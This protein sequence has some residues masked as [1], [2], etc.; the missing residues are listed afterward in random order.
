MN[1]AKK[2]FSALMCLILIVSS[3]SSCAPQETADENSTEPTTAPPVTNYDKAGFTLAYLRTDSLNPYNISGETN[4]DISRLMY[5][6]LFNIGNDFKP[7]P[8]IAESYTFTE[9]DVITVKIKPNL[10]FTDGSA[11]TADDVVYSF[12]LAKRSDFYSPSLKNIT[13][14]S[15]NGNGNIVFTLKSSNPYEVANLCFPVIKKNSDSNASGSSDI[16]SFPIGSGRYF[17]KE[18]NGTEKLIAN[19]TRLGSYIP[20]YNYISLRDVTEVSSVTGLFDLNEVDFYTQSFSEGNYKRYSGTSTYYDTTN[21]VFLGINADCKVLNESKVRR[22]LSL[23]IDRET[24]A[25]SSFSGFAVP[26]S[27]AYH[28]SFYGIKGCSYIPVKS[29]AESAIE[30]LKDAGFKNIS[31]TYSF[32]YNDDGDKLELRLLVNKENSFK[33]SMARNIQ[34]TLAEAD[35]VVNIKEYSYNN[36]IQAIKSGSYDLYIGEVK[37]PESFSLN[38]FFNS[39]G[40]ASF[41]IDNECKSA[42]AY[43]LLLQ[44]E[45]TM[46]EFLDTFADD[47]PF[48]PVLYRR[49]V[50]IKKTKIKT[51]PKTIVSDYLYNINEWTAE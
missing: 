31:S 4:R 37:L 7:I 25:A 44:G 12:V 30:L 15:S 27:T 21:L 26:T 18:E 36:Y 20:V 50:A 11:L 6:P 39:N 41:G 10:K 9:P 38:A 33:L 14:A 17:L 43:K 29:D 1:C 24:V 2:L 45:K 13:D 49:G 32:R 35:I 28:P 16:S 42:E 19:K 46:Q 23:L 47:L 51:S 8:V 22:A 48:I 34:Q 3:F 40:G 5:D